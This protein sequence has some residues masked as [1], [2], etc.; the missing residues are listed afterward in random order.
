MWIWDVIEYVLHRNSCQ[1]L[2]QL[3]NNNI[4]RSSFN[5]PPI[6][7]IKSLIYLHKLCNE[8]FI[9]NIALKIIYYEK[10]EWNFYLKFSQLYFE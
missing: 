5:E 8:A 6:F 3:S 4:H 10:V 7:F 9:S 1:I 2:L